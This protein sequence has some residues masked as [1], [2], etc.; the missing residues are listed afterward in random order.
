MRRPVDGDG[1]VRI[2]ER[3]QRRAAVFPDGRI[4]I[5]GGSDQKDDLLESFVASMQ[6]QGRSEKTVERYVYIISRFMEFAK[7][8]TR[9]INVYHVRNWIA[10]EKARGIQDSTLEAPHSRT[11]SSGEP[12]SP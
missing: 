7:T 12:H 2:D 10:K 9:Q 6:V 5:G 4:E 3:H 1:A 11:E 8:P